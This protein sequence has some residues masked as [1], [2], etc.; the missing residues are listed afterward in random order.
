MFKF[1]S[2]LSLKQVIIIAL[3]F[4]SYTINANVS[5]LPPNTQKL[6]SILMSNFQDLDG[7]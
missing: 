5:T 2:V 7:S 6:Q 4:I 3:F 1:K